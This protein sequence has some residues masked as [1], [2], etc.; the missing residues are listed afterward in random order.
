M[1]KLSVARVSAAVGL[2]VSIV[3][4]WV[5]LTQQFASAQELREQVYRVDQL[6][7]QTVETIK[8]LRIQMIADELNALDAKEQLNGSGLS[9][10]DK[11]R[12]E[13]LKRQWET[14]N[15]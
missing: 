9:Q 8:D 11:V 14:L 4:S 2:I 12:R 7:Q 3:G 6:E 1:E 15:K 13:E 5:F 10:W